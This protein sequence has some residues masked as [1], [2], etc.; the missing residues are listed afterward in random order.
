MSYWTENFKNNNKFE[1]IK[2]D[3]KTDVCIIGAG[4]TG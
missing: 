2:N 4:L 1:S 3:T